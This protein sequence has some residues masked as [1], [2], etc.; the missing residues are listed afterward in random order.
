M[1]NKYWYYMEDGVLHRFHLER[2]EDDCDI[3]NP[4]E[5][6]DGLIG[7]MVCWHRHYNLGDENIKNED[8][9]YYLCGLVREAYKGESIVDYVCSHKTKDN[10]AVSYNEEE[11]VWQLIGDYIPWNSKEVKRSVY[12]ECDKRDWLEDD[13]LENLDTADLLTMLTEKDYVFLPIAMYE[14]SDI[15]IWCGSKWDHFDAQWDC[16]DIGFIYT[17]KK[18]LD[19]VGAPY[20]EENW[21]DVAAK[22]MKAEVDYYDEYIQGN[23]YCFFD[24]TFDP[25]SQEW[26]DGKSCGGF[27]S[28]KWGE[29]LAREIAN[30]SITGEPFIPDDEVEEAIQRVSYPLLYMYG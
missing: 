18:R 5:N 12:G 26:E 3:F 7:T 20:A 28:G 4:R 23:V 19:E 24:E 14:H 10:F 6:D 15:T 30:D 16:S 29:E 13:I 25:Y 8:L 17:T 9:N 11:E 21:R 1:S 27:I 22:D 2:E